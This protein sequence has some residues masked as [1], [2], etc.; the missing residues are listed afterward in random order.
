MVY[1]TYK[2]YFNLLNTLEELGQNITEFKEEQSPNPQKSFFRYEHENFNLDLLPELKAELSFRESY[3]RR[4]IVALEGI[5]IP[6]ISYE[7]L[8][9][10][11]QT[12]SRV[13][14]IND[15]K[16]LESKKKQKDNK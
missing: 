4:Q 5:E 16:H 3:E 7:D 14:D 13:K 8:I 10:D 6:F 2:N 15:I 9:L 12:R 1:P 11:K